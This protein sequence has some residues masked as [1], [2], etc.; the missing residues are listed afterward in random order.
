MADLNNART[1]SIFEPF[2][3]NSVSRLIS[4]E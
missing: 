4:D 3:G 1:K 2:L